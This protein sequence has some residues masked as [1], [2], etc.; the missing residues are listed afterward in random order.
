MTKIDRQTIFKSNFV[1]CKKRNVRT[2]YFE[3]LGKEN[4][5]DEA[6]QDGDEPLSSFDFAELQS[7]HDDEEDRGEHGRERKEIQK[8]AEPSFRSRSNVSKC[9]QKEQ[10]RKQHKDL[11]HHA[12]HHL[13]NR[14]KRVL[15]SRR[16]ETNELVATKGSAGRRA[17]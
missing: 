2:R 12:D 6:G 16:V 7:T 17:E 9:L 13:K 1:D 11:D 14:S 3:R 10:T 5:G 4:R 8:N 15:L